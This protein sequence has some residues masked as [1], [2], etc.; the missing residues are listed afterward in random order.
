MLTGTYSA[1]HKRG[2][3]KW[4]HPAAALDLAM[5]PF[6]TRVLWPGESAVAAARMEPKGPDSRQ[7][8]LVS[9]MTEVRCGRAA[10]PAH[11]KAVR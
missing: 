1:K 10:L 8:L 11:S 2:A 6:P 4:H 3:A 7:T 5:Y 9:P